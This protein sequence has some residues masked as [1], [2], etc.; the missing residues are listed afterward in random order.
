MEKAVTGGEG[1]DDVKGLPGVR[2][3]GADGQF[4][5]TVNGVTVKVTNPDPKGDHILD[6]AGLKPAGDYALIQLTRHSSRSIGLDD[7]VDLRA[8]GTEVFRAFKTAEIFRFTLNDHGYEWGA[9]K[10]SEPEL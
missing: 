6:K 1:R 3:P 10:V 5:T 9:E 7:E 4:F 2:N 8:E